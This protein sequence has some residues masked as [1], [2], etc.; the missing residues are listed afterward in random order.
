MLTNVFRAEIKNINSFSALQRAIEYE[1]DRQIE[2]VEDG[3]EVD[4]ETR[5]WDDNQKVTKT[6]KQKKSYKIKM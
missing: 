6:T 2:I 1:I 5:L 3:G 4:Q